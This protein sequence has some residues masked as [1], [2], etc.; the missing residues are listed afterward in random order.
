VGY[1]SDD[2]RFGKNIVKVCKMTRQPL[3]QAEEYRYWVAIETRWHDNDIYGHVNNTVYYSWF[4]TAV[5]RCLI[6][7]GL[8]DPVD[9]YL[10]GLVVETGCRYAKP[11]SF[12]KSIKVGLLVTHIGNSSVTYN[13]GVFVAGEQGAAAEAYFTHVYVA[14]HNHRPEALPADWRVLLASLG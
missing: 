13:L 8:L 2:T 5:N 6:Q 7:E 11:V 10:I 3:R 4:D 1:F 9:G 12:P 14:R